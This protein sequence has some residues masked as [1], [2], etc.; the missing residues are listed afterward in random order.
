MKGFILVRDTESGCKSLI[1]VESIK[2]VEE[3]AN[4][5]AYV[6]MAEAASSNLKH[7]GSFGIFTEESFSEVIEKISAA[8]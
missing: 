7:T 3:Q 5:K 1:A 4:G 8:E 6:L 2:V